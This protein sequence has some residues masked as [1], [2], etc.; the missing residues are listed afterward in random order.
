MNKKSFEEIIEKSGPEFIL[1]VIGDIA[2]SKGMTQLAK[3]LEIDR[4]G[5]YK[6]LSP[7]GNPSF[8]TIYKVLD[9]LGYQLSVKQKLPA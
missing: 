5:L 1:T 3:D 2:R 9:N 4:K 6:A 8:K 7:D